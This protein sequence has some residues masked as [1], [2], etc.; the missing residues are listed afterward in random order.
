M[1]QAE[2]VK[3]GHFTISGYTLRVFAFCIGPTANICT[4]SGFTEY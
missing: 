3:E 2:V 4:R 1:Q